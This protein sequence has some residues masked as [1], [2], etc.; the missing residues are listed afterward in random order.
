MLIITRSVRN[1]YFPASN[2]R[3]N[4]YRQLGGYFG[5]FDIH[6]C[7]AS[8]SIP[9]LVPLISTEQTPSLSWVLTQINYLRENLPDHPPCLSPLSQFFMAPITTWHFIIYACLC[10]L[11]VASWMS[12]RRT[13]ICL[14]LNPQCPEGWWATALRRHSWMFA[15]VYRKSEVY[16]VKV[17][18]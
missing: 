15:E 6:T 8:T 5:T 10:L 4:C 11:F 7:W 14:L 18:H 2:G 12:V 13:L 1:G 17:Y 9:Q 16:N 3:M